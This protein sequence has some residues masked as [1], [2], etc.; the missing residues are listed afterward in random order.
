[1]KLA[2]RRAPVILPMAIAISAR[3]G[4]CTPWK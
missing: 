2:S 4:S 1:M 3:D